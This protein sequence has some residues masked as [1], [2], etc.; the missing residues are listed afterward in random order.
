MLKTANQALADLWQQA[1]MDQQALRA[2]RLDGPPVLPSSFAVDAAAQASIAAAALAAAEVR[3]LRTG[4]GESVRVGTREA[5]AECSAWMSLDGRVVEPWDPLSGLYPCGA[6]VGAPG[7]VRI[8]ANFAHHRRGAMA[9]LGLQDG[10]GLQRADVAGALRGWR[11]LDYEQAAADAGLAVAA[12]RTFDAWDALPQ[13]AALRE[14]P[15]LAIERIGDAPVQPLPPLP[16]DAP[17]LSGVRVLELT[18]I[19]AGPV[20]GRTLAAHGADVLL[21][22]SPVLPNIEAIAATSLGKR[23]AHLDL[24]LDA[25]REQ[26]RALAHGSDVFMQGYRPGS[27]ATRG[28]GAEALASLRPGI[29]CVSLA[30]YGFT[31]PWSGRR[32]FDSLVQTATGFNAAEGQ[33]AGTAEPRALPVQI[34]DFA[35]GFLMAFGAQVALL[36]RA[37]EGGSWHVRVSLARTGLWLRSLGQDPSGLALPRPDLADRM[38]RHETGFGVLVTAPHAAEMSGAPPRW[39]RPSMP[40]G[41]HPP[42]W[43]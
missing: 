28:F 5:A 14:V 4:L 33:A 37:R 23:S 35:T 12:L 6:D 30:A 17:P 16:A 11:A 26:L 21:V 43:S 10:P 1:G 2:V 3:R 19:L 34:L 42:S 40:P 27:L 22:N 13:A 15:L 24:D 7:H 8:H 39:V 29:V 36:R 18:R 20:A 32:G 41:S 9:L 25:G 38:Q 31:G